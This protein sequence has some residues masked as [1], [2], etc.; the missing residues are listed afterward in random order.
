MVAFHNTRP[1]PPMVGLRTS[2]GVQPSLLQVWIAS[3]VSVM[4]GA[5]HW[6]MSRFAGHPRLRA[7]DTSRK[8]E[9]SGRPAP[10]CA[11][12]P[13][14]GCK[15]RWSARD[16]RPGWNVRR[17][18]LADLLDGRGGAQPPLP[19]STFSSRVMAL[20]S[21]GPASGPCFRNHREAR[22]GPP[23]PRRRYFP[24]LRA[25]VDGGSSDSVATRR[26]GATAR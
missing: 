3:P 8:G 6:V 23:D 7:P 22:S 4:A 9:P 10:A 18:R 12:A 5:T 25:A 1:L 14:P 21:T 20:A 11:L 17:G 19:P 26:L 13:P 24:L 15:R 16:D 2:S